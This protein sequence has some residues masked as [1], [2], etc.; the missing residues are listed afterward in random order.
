MVERVAGKQ[1]ITN[2]IENEASELID[3]FAKT[4]PLIA[5]E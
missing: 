3:V 2:L 5:K 4:E 1:L